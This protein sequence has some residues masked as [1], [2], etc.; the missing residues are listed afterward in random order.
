VTK[1]LL[2]A[3]REVGG[4]DW[5]LGTRPDAGPH[6]PLPDLAGA[7]HPVLGESVFRDAL[8]RERRRADRFGAPFAVLIVDR[9]DATSDADPW[10]TI[11]GA[12]AAVKRDSDSVGW[13]EEGAVLGL[14]LPE[15]SRAGALRVTDRLRRETAAR[16]GDSALAAVSMRLYAHGVEA[17][18]DGAAFPPVDLLIEAFVPGEARPWRDAAKR[19]LDIVGSLAMMALFA[20]LMLAAL[21]AVKWS[22]PGPVML[23]Q[24][25]IGRRGEPFKMLKLRTMYV[26]AGH[27]IHQDYMAWFISSSGKES[28]TGTEFFKLKNDPRVT[29][30]GRILR[31][32][33]L[34]ELP[35]FWNVLRGDMS[36]VGPR[37]PLPFEVEQ[38]QP[39]HRRRVLETKPGITGLWQVSGRSRTTFD[40]MVRLDL[41]YARTHTLWTDIKILAATPRAMLK[42]AI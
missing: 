14:L 33:S 17:G 1:A 23:R 35:Q 40:E 22:S 24:V 16:I 36:L 5:P 27:G 13:I 29:R 32:T 20:P 10:V 7:G 42:G 25:R 15:V 37:P 2:A 38:Y 3:L 31:R 6:S 41:R 12:I 21:A 9:S 26:N 18:P 8:V 11:V 39:W 19:G 30:P 28:R 34:D 4:R